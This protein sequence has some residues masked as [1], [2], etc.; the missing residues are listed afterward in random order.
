VGSKVTSF[1]TGDAVYGDMSSTGWG[2]LAEYACVPEKAVVHKPSG[3]PFVEAAS[4]SHAAN[5]ATQGLIDAGKIQKGQKVLING[6]GG[7]MGMFAI[8]IA[9]M[10]DSE[11]TG[12]DSGDKVNML[13][14]LGFDHIIDYQLEDF[15][16]NG[17]RYDLILDAKTNR[18]LA[19]Y[20]RSMTPDGQYV[21]VGGDLSR[22]ILLAILNL[23]GRKNMSVV[24]LKPNK[25]LEYINQLYEAG[26]LKPIID[27]PY[28]LHEAATA[29]QYFGE[30]K[31]KGK[32][33]ISMV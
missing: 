7:G 12:V 15:T 6:A 10:Y 27:G 31:H 32:V 16:R 2:T 22:I 9:N 19:D 21:T 30:G 17:E 29:L 23:F 33:V 24:G 11:V 8:Q 1:K 18:P 3:M 28:P 26:K 5:L 4:I 25:D 14:S 20:K 13:K